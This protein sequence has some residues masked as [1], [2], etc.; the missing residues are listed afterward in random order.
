MSSINVSHQ[1]LNPYY[2]TGLTDG[3]G[4]FSISFNPRPKLKVGWETRPSFSL[5]QNYRSRDILYK[6]QEYF[7]CGSIRESKRDNCWKYEVRNVEEIANNIIPHFKKYPLQT[8]KIKDFEKFEKIVLLII[9]QK[10]L[11]KE[12]L[13]EIF[14]LTKDM[15][16]SGKRKFSQLVV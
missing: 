11:I 4:S 12:G 6:I 7:N 3:E 8:D 1:T 16:I 2:V 13:S 15:N 14:A 5:A 10:H 9:Q